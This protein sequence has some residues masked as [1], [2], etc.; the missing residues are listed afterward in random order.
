MILRRRSLIFVALLVVLAVAFV[1]NT[2][3]ERQ[4]EDLISSVGAINEG[5]VLGEATLV[6]S[7]LEGGEVSVSSGSVSN[8]YF[9]DARINRQKARDAAI[10]VLQGIISNQSLDE[11]EKRSAASELGIIATISTKESNME[12]L[13]KAKG[14]TDCVVVI[15]ASNVTVVVQTDGLNSSGVSKIK[16]IV[17]SEAIVGADAVNIIEVK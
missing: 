8:G 4:K 17:M 16:E 9:A 13:V 12:N 14:F 10:E 3:M 5:K 15:G 6:D 1:V 11:A 7:S 2:V